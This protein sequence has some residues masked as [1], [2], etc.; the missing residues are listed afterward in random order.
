MYLRRQTR[1][2]TTLSVALIAASSLIVAC[3]SGH[4]SQG[5]APPSTSNSSVVTKSISSPAG[6]AS[7]STST[8]GMS[9]TLAS[10]TAAEATAIQATASSL[11]PPPSSTTGTVTATD[12]GV[13]VGASLPKGFVGDPNFPTPTTATPAKHAGTLAKKATIRHGLPEIPTPRTLKAGNMD[14][15]CTGLVEAYSTDLHT[16]AQAE[17]CLFNE[18]NNVES[19][20]YINTIQDYYNGTWFED[21]SLTYEYH[22]K[23]IGHSGGLTVLNEAEAGPAPVKTAIGMTREVIAN[24]PNQLYSLESNPGVTLLGGFYTTLRMPVKLPAVWRQVGAKFTGDPKFP[25]PTFHPAAGQVHKFPKAPRATVPHGN[26]PGKPHAIK[27]G[28]GYCS[29][30]QEQYSLNGLTWW[31]YELCLNVVTDSS[32]KKSFKS[33]ITWYS[34]QY[35]GD[36]FWSSWLDQFSMLSRGG[37]L[38]YNGH[39]NAKTADGNRANFNDQPSGSWSPWT[40]ADYKVGW[41]SFEPQHYY[42][43][44]VGGYGDDLS[45]A[46]TMGYNPSEDSV[47][48]A[49]GPQGATADDALAAVKKRLQ[50]AHDT[51]I[52]QVYIMGDQSRVPIYVNNSERGRVQPFLTYLTQQAQMV[53]I[54]RFEHSVPKTLVPHL[55]PDNHT[56][57]QARCEHN[58]KA[59][60]AAD[61]T[62][63]NA[64]LYTPADAWTKMNS[65]DIMINA[66]YFD[67]RAFVNG[68]TWQSTNCSVPLGVYFDSDPTLGTHNNPDRLLAGPANYF[69]KTGNKI[70]LDSAVWL[71]SVHG[72][73]KQ[74][75]FGVGIQPTPDDSVAKAAID[76]ALKLNDHV[77]AVSGTALVPRNPATWEEDGPDQG[78]SNTTRIGI[79]YLAAYDELVIIQ[80]GAY[81]GGFDRDQLTFFFNAIGATSAL[82]TDGGGSAAVVVSKA[83]GAQFS[84]EVPPPSSCPQVAAWC[85]PIT[86]PDGKA[87]PVPAFLGMSYTP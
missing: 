38:V 32:G 16:Y 66:N 11:M 65:P 29:G 76:A 79:A 25:T 81:R 54:P 27:D 22:G 56:G 1:R 28:E 26:S 31:Q 40:N 41:W 77:V 59:K 48:G 21:Q 19:Y 58:P 69:G 37:A 72:T 6:D 10:A 20:L 2:R 87:R 50:A 82:E 14:L 60:A 51:G 84:G 13:G 34:I 61:G 7:A 52:P 46:L 71:Q 70:P 53:V 67:T 73:V 36:L 30:K 85:S 63:E 5:A 35:W 42:M 49:F 68:A 55:L 47:A 62:L 74:N 33:V 75:A 8:S 64:E 80:G 78:I 15:S 39:F 45:Y 24:K 43:Y 18:G 83:S 23:L 4:G 44:N 9:A 86:Q 57:D 17:T 3:T 12:V